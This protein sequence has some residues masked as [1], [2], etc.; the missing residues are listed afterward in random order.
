MNGYEVARQLRG[1]PGTVIDMLVALTGYGGL[2]DR[3]RSHEAG[4]DRHLVKPL[5][6]SELEKLLAEWSPRKQA[7]DAYPASDVASAA[8]GVS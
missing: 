4:F 1:Q 3:R 7:E 8:P 6:P 2:E 5:D